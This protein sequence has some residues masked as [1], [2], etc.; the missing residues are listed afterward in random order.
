MNQLLINLDLMTQFR[1]KVYFF[2]YGYKNIVFLCEL[3]LDYSFYLTQKSCIL[4]PLLEDNVNLLLV[5]M[6]KLKLSLF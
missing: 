3:R 4:K 2:G 1:P 6:G 5:K